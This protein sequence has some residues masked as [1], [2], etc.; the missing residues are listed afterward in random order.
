MHKKFRGIMVPLLIPYDKGK[1]VI[2]TDLRKHV[3]SLLKIGVHGFLAPSGTGEFANTTYEER[4]RI[5]RIVAEEVQGQVPVVALVSDCGTENAL[6]CIADA[7]DAGA[8]AVMATP[9]Y[10]SHIDQ[11]G[12]FTF[13][14]TLANEG[15]LPLWLYHQPG[16][17]KLKIDLETVKSLSNN[18]NIVGIKIAAGDDFYYYHSV[19]HAFRR[20]NNF[21]IL[22][23]E[24]HSTLPAYAVGGDGSVSTL[25]NIIP[26]EFI[27][28]YNAVENGDFATARS[29]QDRILNC[30]Q[31]IIMVETGAYQSACKIILKEKGIFSSEL[32]CPPF[33][34]ILSEERSILLKKA[35]ELYLL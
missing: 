18:P 35:K 10:Y 13:F 16:E 26:K 4:K 12:L 27:D 29:L 1:K 17:T 22:M 23:G 7:K 6:R 28:I 25:A 11:R 9:P 21:S 19:V 20:R 30:F 32:C 33:I 34:D 14:S 24:D 2:E 8:D 15:A 31:S 5:T 3:S